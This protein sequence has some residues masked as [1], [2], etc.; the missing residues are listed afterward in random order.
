MQKNKALDLYWPVFFSGKKLM[1]NLYFRAMKKF[2]LVFLLFPVLAEAQSNE[3]LVKRNDAVRLADG[4]V[5]TIAS[6][7]RWQ[8][9]DWLTFGGV[10]AGTALVTLLDEPVR[11]FWQNPD[12]KFLDGMERVGYHYG[13]PYS[14]FIS[15]GGFYLAGLI[16]D[17]EWAKDTGLMLGAAFLSSGAIQTFMKT[18]AGRAR[19]KAEKGNYTFD[20]FSGDALYHAFPSGHQAVALSTSLILASRVK[21]PA[22]KIIFYSG[23]AVTAFSRMYSDNHWFSDIAFGSA[24]AYFC[25][26]TVIA[27][28]E[29]KKFKKPGNK[30]GFSWQVAPFPGGLSIKASIR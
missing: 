25:A 3:N 22:L 4:F 19:P 24:L 20:P 13:K 17:D 29:A 1:A 30:S 6:P 16:L 8:G 28:I 27:R 23:A 11:D 10:V 5:Y 26:N 14:A 9:N 2:L 21:S 18:A 15:T 7:G 12:S